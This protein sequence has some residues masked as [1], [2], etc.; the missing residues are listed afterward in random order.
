MPQPLRSLQ[1]VAALALSACAGPGPDGP[2]TRSAAPTALEAPAGQRFAAFRGVAVAV[3]DDWGTEVLG[4]CGRTPDG[5]VVFRL[6]GRRHGCGQGPDRHR[7]WV[8]LERVARGDGLLLAMGPGAR[9]DGAR[10]RETGLSCRTRTA[11]DQ[12]LAVPTLGVLVQ[13]HARGERARQEVRAIGHSLSL[14]PDGWTSVPPIPFGTSDEDAL[15]LLGEAGLEG[16]VPDVDWPHYVTGSSPP[17]GTVIEEGSVVD[18]TIG[19]G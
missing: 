15:A 19:D 12:V 10:V 3:P 6:P 8:L 17:P 11:C 9:V 7:S 1:L 5:A 16:R 14:V 4:T 13:V 18:L 2:A